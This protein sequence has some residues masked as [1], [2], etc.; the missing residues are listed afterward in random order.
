MMSDYLFNA[1]YVPTLIDLDRANS[2]DVL[3]SYFNVYESCMYL[4]PGKISFKT[5]IQT[6]HYQ[7]GGG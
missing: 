2:V 6:D 3:F 5:G 1:N 7:L 4:F